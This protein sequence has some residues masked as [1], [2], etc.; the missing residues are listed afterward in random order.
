MKISGARNEPLPD[1]RRR[2]PAK[3]SAPPAGQPAPA[4]AAA[5]LGLSEADL[6]PAVQQA[7]QTLLAEVDD[8]RQEVSRLK[9][10]LAEVEGLADQDA[11]TPLLNRRAFMRELNRIRTFAQRYGSPASLIYFDVDGLKAINDRFGHAAGDAALKAIAERL[12]AN[13]RE[14]DIVGR[15]GG[16]EFAVVLVQADRFTAK[17][18]AESLAAQIS[19]TPIQ[20][21]DWS[22]PLRL[23]FGVKDISPEMEPEAIVAE[24]DAAMYA[25]KRARKA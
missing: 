3:A 8:L 1:L 19:D 22:M 17:A 11:L 24:A 6:T 20:L 14:S 13:V 2:A 7:L 12:L 10:R 18:K 15:M 21:G 23:S 4:D 16:D 25:M 5:F 9:A